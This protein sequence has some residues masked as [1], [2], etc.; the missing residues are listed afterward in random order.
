[1]LLIK[2]CNSFKKDLKKYK[3][4]CDVL[5]E[6]IKVVDFLA[7]EKPLPIKYQ[8]HSLTGKFIQ[9]KDVQELHLCP[10]DLLVYYKVK[11]ESIILVA[12]GSH[13]ELF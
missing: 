1:M 7:N 4:N 12:I 5:N 8:N 3:H 13:S 2:R 9:Y 11:N 10:D 6:L